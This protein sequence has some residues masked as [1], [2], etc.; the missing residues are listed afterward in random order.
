MQSWRSPP[1]LCSNALMP[2][3]PKGILPT[4][5]TGPATGLCGRLA[6]M[7]LALLVGWLLYEAS[8]L[9]R[10]SDEVPTNYARSYVEQSKDPWTMRGPTPERILSPLLANCL[11]MTGEPGYVHFTE[12]TGVLLLA[13]VFAY[14]R[15]RRGNGWD[16]L[17]AT[18][19]VAC[20]GMIQV[21]K[22]Y[23]GLPDMLGMA[24]LVAGLLLVRSPLWFWGI[25][26]LGLLNHG[27]AV[28]LGPWLLFERW[29]AA[30]G[31]TRRDLAAMAGC[32]IVYVGLRVVATSHVPGPVHDFAFFFD[33]FQLLGGWVRV[34]LYSLALVHASIV[35]G[36]LLALLVWHRRLATDRIVWVRQLLL[37]CSVLA[38][39]SIATDVFRFA[40]LW[41]LLLIE[42]TIVCVVTP[43]ARVV[44]GV[45][46]GG[47]VWS[48]WRFEPTVMP[49]LT[50][51]MLQ[52]NV[53][54]DDSQFVRCFLPRTWPV[55]A[56]AAGLLLGSHLLGILLA[57]RCRAS[58]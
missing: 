3:Q 29:V 30:R 46:V 43:R 35:F 13:L 51:A 28:F 42:A 11:G 14:V 49:E 45:L 58:V 54:G 56:A 7:L 8:C 21:Y 25:Y 32:V 17:L 10:P 50:N 37:F 20:T 16:A 24:L 9:L 55:F 26:C 47:A 31:L 52:C 1:S 6:A 39:C 4:R 48:I 23:A 41:G 27:M 57:R 2:A 33:Q 5:P 40:N 12:W 22:H 19:G 38:I 34:G 18:A 15:G 36:P 44:F 53:M